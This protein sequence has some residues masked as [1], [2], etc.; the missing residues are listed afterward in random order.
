MRQCEFCG[1]ATIDEEWAKSRELIA[2]YEN[3][4]HYFCSNECKMRYELEHDR[5]EERTEPS[6]DD[7]VEM[8]HPHA[9]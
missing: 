4:P 1:N 7:V 8:P 9:G 6:K 3:K 2:W 5:F